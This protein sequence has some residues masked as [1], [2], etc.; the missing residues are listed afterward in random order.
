MRKIERLIECISNCNGADYIEA[1]TNLGLT[2]EDFKGKI[3]FSE[4]KYT[5]TCII[6]NVAYELILLGWSKGQKTAIHN[7][8][9]HEGFVYALDGKIKE[10]TYKL[11]TKTNELEKTGEG[12]L[13]KNQVSVAKV[14]KNE[15]HSIENIHNGSTLTLHLYKKPIESCLVYDEKKDEMFTKKLVYDF[16]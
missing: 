5:R 14:D 6:N 15:F 9:G 12:I 3:N 1:I 2:K 7:H 16:V 10:V 13:L 4:E 8:D 11:N